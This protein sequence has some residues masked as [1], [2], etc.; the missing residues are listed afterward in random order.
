[1]KL[2]GEKMSQNERTV[3]AESFVGILAANIDNR[4]MTDAEFRKF[5]RKT[6]TIVKYDPGRLPL[7]DGRKRKKTVKTVASSYNS[8][9]LARAMASFRSFI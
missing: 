2:T 8:L 9:D 4:K 6:I 7:Y 3:P 5:I 1:M